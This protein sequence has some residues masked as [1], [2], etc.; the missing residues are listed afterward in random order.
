MPAFGR[1]DLVAAVID[2]LG[3]SHAGLR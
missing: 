3:R 1:Y 2:A